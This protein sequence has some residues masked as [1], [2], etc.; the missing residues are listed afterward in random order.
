MPWPKIGVTHYLTQ[1]GPP[2]KGRAIKGLAEI[3]DQWGGSLDK[4]KV[5]GLVPYYG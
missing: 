5:H 2:D 1:L 3:Y 4:R